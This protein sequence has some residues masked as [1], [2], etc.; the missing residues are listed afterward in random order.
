MGARRAPSACPHVRASRACGRDRDAASQSAAALWHLAVAGWR[1]ARCSG[2]GWREARCGKNASARAG[3][4]TYVLHVKNGAAGS[5]LS[6]A[7]MPAAAATPAAEQVPQCA[8]F[9]PRAKG[10]SLQH[11]CQQCRPDLGHQDVQ[12]PPGGARQPQE[13]GLC[14]ALQDRNWGAGQELGRS[15]ASQKAHRMCNSGDV[16]R[17]I[18]AELCSVGT[19]HTMPAWQGSSCMALCKQRAPGSLQNCPPL[20]ACG[21]RGI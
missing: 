13:L 6:A 3:P 17:C 9:K 14:D 20:D 10:C 12:A 1:E 19:R 18:P 4:T 16:G 11:S 7:I 21:A 15:T 5:A 8:G 2:N